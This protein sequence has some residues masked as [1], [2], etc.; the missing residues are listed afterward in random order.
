MSSTHETFTETTDSGFAANANWSKCNRRF[1]V[2]LYLKQVSGGVA[3]WVIY[4]PDFD[5]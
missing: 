4:A 5:K 1:K 2:G 3:L